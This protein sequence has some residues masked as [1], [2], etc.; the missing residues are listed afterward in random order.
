MRNRRDF[1]VCLAPEALGRDPE[2]LDLVRWAGCDEVWIA[3]FFYGYWPYGT[4]ELARWKA[5][6]EHLGLAVS[7]SNIPLGHPG[8]SLGSQDADA[9]PL[10]PPA[11]W[12]LGAR[13]DGSHYSGTSL[14]PPATEENC[15]A[16]R[17]LAGRGYRKC[18]LDDDFRLAISPG[19]IGGCFCEAHKQRF[20]E[21]RGYGQRQWEELLAEVASRSLSRLVREW[22][23]FTCDDLTA[24]F[25]AQQE[26]AGSMAM[27]NMVMFMGAEKAGIRLPDYTG[28]LFRVGEGHFD[29][30][31]FGT[32]KGKCNELFSAL[33]HRRFTPG[34]L[35]WSETTAYP[36]TA[37]SARNMAAKLAISTLADVRHT[38]YMSGLTPFPKEHWDVLKPAMAE[39]KRLHALVMDSTPRGP[40]KH[41][42]GEAGRYVGDDNPYSLWLACGVPFEVVDAPTGEGWTFVA[43]HDQIALEASGLASQ[44]QCVTRRPAVGNL[45]GSRALPEDLSALWEFKE[46]I[47]PQLSGAPYVEEATPVVCAWYPEKHIVLL[48]NLLDEPVRVTLAFGATHRPVELPALGM[49]AVEKVGGQGPG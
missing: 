35:A 10:T 9:F 21:S 38:L 42:W 46:S 43:E 22:V 49:T 1:Q 14:H 3:A 7:V 27:G 13:P 15:A 25:R 6:G 40:F 19:Q 24:S 33:F 44:C 26:A 12:Q 48:W 41:Y 30:G 36:A 37:L 28:A 16:V 8:D 11:H 17:E 2:L 20:L 5:T 39:Q 18:F 45:A 23:D 32:L 31:S 47:K 29:D 4:D 34:H